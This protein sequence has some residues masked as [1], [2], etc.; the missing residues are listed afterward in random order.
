MSQ[1]S[2]STVSGFPS[3]PEY[4]PDQIEHRRQIARRLNIMNQGKFN[5][6][7]DVTLNA[8][9]GATVIADN[10]IGYN[11]AVTPLMALSLSGA[12]AIAAGIWCDGLRG[13]FGSTSASVTVH[14]AISSATDQTIRFGIFG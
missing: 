4:L 12:V 6:T 13:S 11:S 14:H 5:V 10:R 3:I 9:T 1:T 8:A 2:V 7:K